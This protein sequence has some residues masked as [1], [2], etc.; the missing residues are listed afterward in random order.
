MLRTTLAIVVLLLLALAAVSCGDDDISGPRVRIVLEPPADIEVSN[1]DEALDGVLEILELRIEALGVELVAVERVGQDQ[2][3]V[4]LAGVTPDEAIV[5]T[6]GRTALLQFC[7]P[8]ID[9]AGNVAILQ[10]GIVVYKSLTCEP[11]RD[12]DGSIVVEAPQDTAGNVVES[13]EVAFVPWFDDFSPQASSN[14]PNR[15]LVWEPATAEIDGQVLTL[16]GTYLSPDTFVT[17]SA[18]IFGNQPSLVF[19][20]RG[21]G[22][23]ISE[24]VTTRLAER[25][26]PL[27][28]WLAGEPILDSNGL[29]IAPH[30]QT[31]ITSGGQITGLD[32]ETAQELSTLL[33]TGAFP[34]PLRVVEIQE[35]LE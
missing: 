6:I 12:A 8:V 33:N 7:R 27:S 32:E 20:W 35:V 15:L 1:L 3:V 29:I 26:Y 13:V 18:T 19:N 34:I 23:D 21:D 28:P 30:V 31:V 2:I 10:E 22:P 11:M 25:N 17:F 24:A 9:S 14:P 4:E 16:D 5:A